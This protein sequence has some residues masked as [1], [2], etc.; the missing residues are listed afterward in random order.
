MILGRIAGVFGVRG[1]VKVFS[2]TEPREGIADYSP[3]WLEVAGERRAYRV[4]EVR[5][6][7]QGVVASLEGVGDRD[8][9]AALVGAEISVNRADLPPTGQDEVYWTDLEGLRVE[10]LDGRELGTVSHLFETGANDVM[11]VVG[12]RERLI[13]YLPDKVVHGVDLEAGVVRVD[14]DPEF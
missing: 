10:T 4:L 13:P 2:H 14:W 11:V 1:Q 3:W 12:D 9:A 6:H 7:G 5:R 8:Q